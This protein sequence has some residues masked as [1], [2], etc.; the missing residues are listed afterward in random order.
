[1]SQKAKM[2]ETV[3]ARKKFDTSLPKTELDASV[4]EFLT[5]C[6]DKAKAKGFKGGKVST[7]GK[8]RTV[9]YFGVNKSQC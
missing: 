6:H 1:M 8:D 2:T 9:T 4:N 7:N 5:A 3:I